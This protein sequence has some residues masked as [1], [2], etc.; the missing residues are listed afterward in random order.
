MHVLTFEIECFI[1]GKN[2]DIALY[3]LDALFRP[4]TLI[5]LIA[6]V[7]IEWHSTTEDRF[8]NAD[9]CIFTIV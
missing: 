6:C 9:T 2:T 3:L 4:L 8:A 5:A 7:C 1:N